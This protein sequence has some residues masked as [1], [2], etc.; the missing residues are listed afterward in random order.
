[1]ESVGGSISWV[2]LLWGDRLPAG[3]IADGGDQDDDSIAAPSVTHCTLFE[4]RRRPF[5]RHV[6]ERTDRSDCA[7]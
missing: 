5:W 3:L 7:F 6:I 1:M 4:C 2:L